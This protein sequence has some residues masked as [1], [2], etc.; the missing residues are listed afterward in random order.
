M[1]NFNLL[2]NLDISCFCMGLNDKK[3]K[4]TDELDKKIFN[5]SKEYK[6]SILPISPNFDIENLYPL[7]DHVESWNIFI[8]GNDKTYILANINDKHIMI[9][10]AESLPNK[11]GQSVLPE[12]LVILFDGL[13]CKTLQ[14]KQLQFYMVW[15][16]KL[17]FV[18]TYPFYNGVNKIIGAILFMRAFD[19]MPDTKLA[20][21]DINVIPGVS[22]VRTSEEI[23]GSQLNLDRPHRLSNDIVR[24]TSE[25]QH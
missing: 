20:S 11:L 22:R 12:E 15:N 13:W 24:R 25:L 6:I 7:T 2:E 10:N 14:G 5:L 9:P 16:G 8:V 4:Y 1:F 3:V 19:T 18:N 21:L 17:Y 23:R